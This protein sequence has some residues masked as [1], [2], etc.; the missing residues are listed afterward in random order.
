[1]FNIGYIFL[2]S[3]SEIDVQSMLIKSES[4]SSL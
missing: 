4:N 3:W 1:M 2:V